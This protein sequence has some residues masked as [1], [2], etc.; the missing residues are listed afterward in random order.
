MFW[1]R[2]PTASTAAGRWY[3]GDELGKKPEKPEVINNAQVTDASILKRFGYMVWDRDGVKWK[4]S[5]FDE[6][7]EQIAHCKL[8][9]RSLTCKKD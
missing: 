4:G 3:R 7:G 6:N 9:E 1:R 2:Q 8:A 5:L